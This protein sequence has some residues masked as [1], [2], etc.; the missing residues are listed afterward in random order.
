MLGAANGFF[1]GLVVIGAMENHFRT[2]GP[3]GGDFD[4]R[5]GEGHADLGADTALACVISQA[6]GMIPGGGRDDALT[7]SSLVSVKSLFSAP[8][9]LNAPVLCRLSSFR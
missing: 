3:G 8:R 9:S 5:G 2:E 7:R 4:Q 1:A 6:L